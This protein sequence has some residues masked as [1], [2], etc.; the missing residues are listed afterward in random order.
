MSYQ[1]KSGGGEDED[2]HREKSMSERL[3]IIR[4]KKEQL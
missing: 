2:I 3:E 4:A 1:N